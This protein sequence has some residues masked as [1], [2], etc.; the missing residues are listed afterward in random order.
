MLRPVLI[1]C[2]LQAQT[3]LFLYS[4]SFISVHAPRFSPPTVE[5]ARNLPRSKEKAPFQIV[6]GPLTSTAL[7]TRTVLAISLPRYGNL[8]TRRTFQYSVKSELQNRSLSH[9]R[10]LEAESRA[11]PRLGHTVYASRARLNERPP[12][13]IITALTIYIIYH[14]R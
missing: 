14:N 7:G 4:I 6:F 8:T 13:I 1:E 9:P 10:Q 11:H 12:T 5:H 3:R 2:P